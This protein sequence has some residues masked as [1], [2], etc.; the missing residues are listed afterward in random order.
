MSAFR[1]RGSDSWCTVLIT[2]CSLEPAIGME[3]GKVVGW[4]AILVR[5]LTSAR[6]NS[7]QPKEF[8]VFIEQRGLA[9]L[10]RNALVSVFLRALE[11]YEAT[12][13][14]TS[15]RVGTFDEAFKSRIQLALHYKPL[16]I[17]QR[18]KIWRNFSSGSRRW[19]KRML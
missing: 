12:L 18:K 9:N 19:A 7:S 1:T 17:P 3:G 8:D 11:Y 10:Q 6:S 5:L 2:Y 4:R 16:T 14:L 13:I 15:S